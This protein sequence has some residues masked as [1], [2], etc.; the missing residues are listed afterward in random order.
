LEAGIVLGWV[1]SIVVTASIGLSV[2]LMTALAATGVLLTVALAMLTKILIGEERFTFYHYQLAVIAAAAVMLRVLHQPILPYLDLLIVVLGTALA[3]GRLGCMMAGCCHGRP[4]DWGICYGEDHAGLGFPRCLVGVRL[5]PV[6]VFESLLAFGLVI[7]SSALIVR[8]HAA[9][10]ALSWY[11]VGYG[12]GRFFLEFMR[13]DTDRPC[14]WGLSEAQ[15]TSLVV[16]G[17]VVWGQRSGVLPEKKL[18]D[19][20]AGCLILFAIT[21]VLAGGLRRDH[22]LMLAPHVHELAEV[23]GQAVT[24]TVAV[25][26]ARTEPS[27]VRVFAT[28]EGIQVS[29]GHLHNQE[30]L[31]F[32][33]A[34]STAGGD[35][36][37]K[38]ATRLSNLI[39]RLRHPDSFMKIMEG[40]HGVF[41]LLIDQGENNAESPREPARPAQAS[42]GAGV[43]PK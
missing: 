10:E 40:G 7:A 16:I 13:G 43:F 5:F 34:L 26:A 9:G 11:L 25:P 3:C 28:S 4:H 6:Q 41:H 15:W 20:M 17:A 2:F 24:P 22:R 36:S 21:W 42:V 19:G 39:R 29:A 27:A 32:H 31:V 8:G 14:L 23:I 1:A 35:L 37:A 30:T 18:H 12:I 33:Y 38:T